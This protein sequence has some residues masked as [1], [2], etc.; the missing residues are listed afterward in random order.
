MSVATDLALPLL[1]AAVVGCT[2]LL[3]STC[4][5]LHCQRA[6]VLLALQSRRDMHGSKDGLDEFAEMA[7]FSRARTTGQMS[8]VV[9]KLKANLRQALSPLLCVA[10][11]CQTATCA[12]SNTCGAHPWLC[13]AC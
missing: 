13:P 12:L 7:F 8:E 4:G 5:I 6:G 1:M 9:D 11:S 10:I 3:Q 2:L